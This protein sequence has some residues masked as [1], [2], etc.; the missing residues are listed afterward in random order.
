MNKKDNM[1]ESKKESKR[2][3][4]RSVLIVIGVVCVVWFMWPFLYHRILNI[5]NVTGI[6]V[7]TILVLYGWKMPAIH[8]MIN[9]VWEKSTGKIFLSV[10]SVCCIG[11]ITLAI[12]LTSCMLLASRKDVKKE[13]TVVVLGCKVYG[14][15]ASLMLSE[16]LDTAYD[17]LVEN[18][19]VKC[20]VSGGKGYDE[21]ISEAECMYRYLTAKG[22][23]KTRIYKEDQ[24]TSTRENIRFSYEII[25][26]N[27][28][29]TSIAIVTN[30]FHEYRAGKIADTLGLDYGAVSA[31]TA[32]WLF[33]TYYIRE[34]YGILYE[35]VL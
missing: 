10:I 35:W 21:D 11:V 16:R 23:D 5:G 27:N 14:E 19:N 13:A 3:G 25:Q 26:K 6:I 29:D 33:P 24:S 7:S 12:I 4:I 32:W 1:N 30:D 17:Y 22:I 2:M 15:R 9:V 34:L 20:I 8:K 31:R 28:L 18:P